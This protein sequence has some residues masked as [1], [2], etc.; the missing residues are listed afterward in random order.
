MRNMHESLVAWSVLAVS[1][2]LV[3][4][5]CE[6]R[7]SDAPVVVVVPPKHIYEVRG[8]ITQL[9]DADAVPPR[10]LMI[11]H[12]EVTEFVGPNGERGMPA[13]TMPFPLRDGE[14][15]EGLEVGD[16]VA[17]RFETDWGSG[18]KYRAADLRE[19]PEGTRLMFEGGE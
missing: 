4:S 6:E 19:L 2:A 8:Q 12:E 11:R 5:G 15:L 16:A 10:Q 18:W 17:F 3:F 7:S 1:I 13:M 14:S 9:P